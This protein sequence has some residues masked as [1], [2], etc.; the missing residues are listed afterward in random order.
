VRA[1]LL[2]HTHS[3]HW[4]DHTLGHLLRRSLPLWC[5]PAHHRVLESYS[6]HFPRL[7]AAGLVRDYQ[8]HVEFSA[9]GLRCRALPVRHDSGVT[10]GFRLCGTGDL[11]GQAGAVGYAADLGSW[12][13]ALAEALAD[14]D[15][16]ALEFNHD[17]GLECASG[18]SPS[19]I[20]RVLGDDGHLSNEQAAALLRAVLLRSKPGRPRHIV[21]LHLSRDCNR[22]ALAAAAARR[23]LEELARE[24]DV[25]TASQDHV[26]PTLELSAV[27]T[28]AR[29]ARRRARA[30][31][32]AVP[33]SWLPGLE[34]V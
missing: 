1:M 32:P 25:R 33:E 8:A 34:N 10:F 21:Q 28:P 4:N 20:A 29:R 12:D 14:V 5:H 6:A 30:P 7:K 22:P 23:V 15:V 31:R 11:F 9:A 19:L 24:V 26:G 18:R 2:T 27:P 3:D 13:D 17:V 16:L